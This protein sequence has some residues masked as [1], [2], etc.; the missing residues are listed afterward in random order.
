MS[1]FENNT[2]NLDPE[3][4]RMLDDVVDR[5]RFSRVTFTEA[6]AFQYIWDE[7][8]EVTPQ[9]DDRFVLAYDGQQRH[10]MLSTHTLANNL[11]LEALQT[12]LWDGQELNEELARI[13]EKDQAHYVFCP[14][15]ER[16]SQR[17]DGTW[18]PSA[19]E[20]DVKLSKARK[21]E[22]ESLGEELLGRW[23][24][25]GCQPWTVRQITSVLTELGWTQ[26]EQRGSWMIVRTWLKQWQMVMRAGADYWILQECVPRL[27]EQTHTR[28]RP[29]RGSSDVGPTQEISGKNRTVLE[30]DRE[31]NTAT[32]PERISADTERYGVETRWTITLRTAHLTAGYVPIPSR[33]R[34]AYPPRTPDQGDVTILKGKW[35]DTGEDIWVWLDRSQDRLFGPEL[36]DNIQWCD[37]GQKLHIIWGPDALVFRPGEIDQNVQQEET[38]LVDLDALAQLRAGLSES[39]RQSLI[40][41]L[42]EHAS[43]LTFAQVVQELRARQGHT[44]HS[45]TIRAILSAG[46]FSVRDGHWYAPQD[47]QASARNARRAYLQSLV[48]SMSV[49][50]SDATVSLR[51][52]A[53]AI[54]DCLRELGTH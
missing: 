46:G 45:G 7:G 6:E 54:Q 4:R 11:L 5:Y 3:L 49:E 10:W 28:V 14:A 40:T 16:F 29:V 19:G 9:M 37:A 18:E 8:N 33:A 24:D 30:E 31:H 34:A 22:L 35:Y 27:S 48:T 39:Y 36:S 25:T 26:A 2:H 51:T 23:R 13:S 15:D 44:V 32:E 50:S 17:E 21:A 41:I 52:T 53:R 38:R 12:G 20:G 43:G 1:T 47:I 42:S